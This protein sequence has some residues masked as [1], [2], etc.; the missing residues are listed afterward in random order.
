M[1]FRRP[2][3]EKWWEVKFWTFLYSIPLLSACLP[4]HTQNACLRR[5]DWNNG[6]I[7]KFGAILRLP[8]LNP[9]HRDPCGQS[10]VN[11]EFLVTL[12][13]VW[14]PWKNKYTIL[15]KDKRSASSQAALMFLHLHN[16]SSSLKRL[17]WLVKIVHDIDIATDYSSPL[18]ENFTLEC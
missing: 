8:S 12:S 4:T 16:N 10:L 7:Y 5:M 6:S 3:V 14:I 15:S 18:G 13:L 17:I 1:L 2:G 9:R 11:F